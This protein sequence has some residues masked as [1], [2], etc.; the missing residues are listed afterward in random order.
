MTWLLTWNTYGTRL[1]G[2]ARGFVSGVRAAAGAREVHNQPGTPVDADVPALRRYAASVMAHP[3]VLL[4]PHHAAALMGQFRETAAHRG[5]ALAALAVMANHVHLV[6]E[7]PDTISGGRLLADFKA[8]A[9][10]KLDQ[11][12]AE[13]RRWWTERGSTRALKCPEAVSAAVEYVKQQHAPLVVWYRVAELA[14]G[15]TSVRR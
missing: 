14:S 9:T 1:P 3:I 12:A 7:C 8:Y 11:L 15:A 6:V 10:R 2:D 4:E 5:W 13:P